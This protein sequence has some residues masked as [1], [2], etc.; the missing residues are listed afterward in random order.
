MFFYQRLISEAISI[1]KFRHLKLNVFKSL[2]TRLTW[3]FAAVTGV[4]GGLRQTLPAEKTLDERLLLVGESF[5]FAP[6]HHLFHI[7]LRFV[8]RDSRTPHAED[9]LSSHKTNASA[10]DA[11]QFGNT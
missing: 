10:G 7:V 5:L 4:E 1:E 2:P 8:D 9:G 3:V 6:S 11:P